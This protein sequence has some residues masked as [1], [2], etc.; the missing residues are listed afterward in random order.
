[1]TG[2]LVVPRLIA[3]D[4]QSRVTNRAEAISA[5]SVYATELPRHRIDGDQSISSEPIDPRKLMRDL[6]AFRDPRTGQSSWEL[7]ITLLPFLTLF[8]LIAMAVQA[9]YWL[10][11]AAT[12]LAG[13]FLLRL[14]IIQHDCGHGAF[15]PNRAGNDW[16]GRALGVFTLTPYDC[17]RRSHAQ[18]HAATGNLDARGIGD[19][20]TLTL[21]EYRDRSRMGRLLYRLYRHPVVL[22][23]LGP[24]YL[25][26]LRHRLPVGLMKEGRVYW[27]SAIA[28]NIVTALILALP[29]YFFGLGVT[30][31]VFFPVLL[32]AASMGVWLFYVQHQFPDAHWDRADDWSFHDAALH[33]SSH[34][35]LPPVLGWFTG[36]IGIHHV[37][38]LA[39]RIPF[40][41]LPEV[42][43]KHPHLRNVNRFTALQACGTLRLA[44]WDEDRRGMITFR[45]ASRA[46]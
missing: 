37:H 12:P 5:D 38:H 27:Y 42:L 6:Q 2:H 8:A 9:G 35:D 26:L 46:G 33:G 7:A 21:R 29:L 44:L 28:T 45:E 36:Y 23:G 30:A 40:Y 39:S 25:F 17:W 13:L 31:L 1:M 43:E 4:M 16:I 14:F 15:L 3:Q 22:L 11:L 34:L 19:V 10:A 20:D 41:R 18:H 32:S 24:A